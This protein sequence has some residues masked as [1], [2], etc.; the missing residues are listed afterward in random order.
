MLRVGGRRIIRSAMANLS[1]QL[2]NYSEFRGS[3]YAK[4]LCRSRFLIILFIG[5]RN[6]R[7]NPNNRRFWPLKADFALFRAR[8]VRLVFCEIAKAQPRSVQRVGALCARENTRGGVKYALVPTPIRA[9]L[10]G[11]LVCDYPLI[12]VPFISGNDF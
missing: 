10:V 3:R 8:F 11:T 4:Q 1:L 2:A 6:Y 9:R 5:N 7:L 12:K